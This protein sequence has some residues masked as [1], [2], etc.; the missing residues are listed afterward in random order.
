MAVKTT[1]VSTVHQKT[2]S[3]ATFVEGGKRNSE[4]EFLTTHNRRA[5]GV[6]RSTH[7]PHKNGA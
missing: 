5:G 4:V 2:R 6:P 7:N 3:R 1:T